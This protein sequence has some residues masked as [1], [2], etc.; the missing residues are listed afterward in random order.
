[1]T[2]DS[3]D[4]KQYEKF[5]R[6]RTAPFFDLLKS[7]KVPVELKKASD[8]RTAPAGT[9]GPPGIRSAADLS[10]S[11]FRRTGNSMGWCSRAQ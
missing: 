7:K 2:N 1:M 6:E 11:F 5:L 8:I 3:W 4:P 9:S 10:G